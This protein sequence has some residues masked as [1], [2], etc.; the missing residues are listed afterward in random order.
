MIETKECIEKVKDYFFNSPIRIR[1]SND[2]F[3]PLKNLIIENIN[4]N[5]KYIY[6]IEE[7]EAN[8]LN[9]V[10]V[11]EVKSGKSTFLNAIVYKYVSEVD[12]LES[13]SS[14]IEVV[15][16]KEYKKEIE[17]GVTKISLDL[18]IL[19]KINLVDTPGIRSM[20]TKNENHTLRYIQKADFIIFILDATHIGQ[21]DIINT[22]E[23]IETFKKPII[24]VVNKGDL[25]I[26]DKNEVME[27]IK[28]E[29]GI[30]IDKFFLI[31]SYTQYESAKCIDNPENKYTEL[32]SNF[33]DLKKYID[34]LYKDSKILKNESI[35]SSIKG[36]IQ[37][38]IICNYDYYK[39]ISMI[40][41]EVIK[42]ENILSKKL[43]YI[44]SKMNF[45]IDD[46]IESIFFI[47]EIER[48]SE[49]INCYN[50]YV[51]EKYINQYINRKKDELDSLY[52]KEWEECL[53]EVQSEVDSIINKNIENIYYTSE[54]LSSKHYDIDKEEIKI[55]DILATAGTGAVFGATTG[56]IA[57]I[58]TS[59]IGSSSAY[60][61]IGSAMMTYCPP[62]LI[63]GTFTG[64]IGKLIYDKLK[65]EKE[66]K[67]I[68][69]DIEDF[70]S[71][72]KYSVKEEL[73]CNY[74]KCSNEI[75]RTNVELYK[76]DKGISIG[77]YELSKLL[78]EIESYINKL[79]EYINL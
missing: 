37:K 49:N 27:Y 24:G 46:W 58:Y 65:K 40:N 12:V 63:A 38:E 8:P 30:Y 62:L 57:S 13:T 11:G 21:E 71:S 33:L 34:G 9:L 45:E 48:I 79:K 56:A 75:L 5:I 29:Y 22:L 39:S 67:L 43:D 66:D 31:S 44:I 41:D 54:V 23:L 72:L 1:L 36:V 6:D 60:I 15:Y 55:N 47:D 2:E 35:Q 28:E 32:N 4:Q 70:I 3:I 69:N 52:F 10:I 26:D 53:S 76:K 73:K 17:D 68:L 18:D 7:N 74:I 19:K 50:E 77:I 42:Y 64:A 20:N 25:L 59:A 51:N 14:I 16:G 61:S 78:N